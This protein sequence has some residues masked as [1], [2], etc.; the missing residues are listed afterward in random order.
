MCR[1]GRGPAPSVIRLAD[2]HHLA[3][4][5]RG[6]LAA[7]AS[8][9]ELAGRLHPTAAVCGTPPEAAM[10]LI[11]ELERMD[12]GR[13]AGPVG[14]MDARGDGAWGLA[15]HCG[16]IAGSRARLFAGCGLV[17]GSEP[18]AELA[19]AD[20]KFQPMLRALGLSP[21]RPQADPQ[22]RAHDHGR[23]GQGRRLWPAL[24]SESS[25]GLRQATAEDGLTGQAAPSPSRR[26]AKSEVPN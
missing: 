1:P 2:T 24:A 15:L 21:I 9:L 14:W 17:A 11:R 22:A 13:Y 6:T 23:A 8:A 3:T 18:A 10:N 20:A 26:P 5:I 4:A 7:D 25:P 16:E 19:E 12:R